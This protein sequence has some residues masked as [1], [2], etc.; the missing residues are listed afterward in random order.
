LLRYF[1]ASAILTQEG[2]FP[3]LCH[4]LPSAWSKNLDLFPNEH[5]DSPL[6][7]IRPLRLKKSLVADLYSGKFKHYVGSH[8][9]FSGDFMIF[10]VMTQEF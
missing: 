8:P 3:N 4:A 1:P 9:K 5:V 10:M 6:K 2:S 7:N